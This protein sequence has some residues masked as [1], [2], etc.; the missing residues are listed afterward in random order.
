MPLGIIPEEIKLKKELAKWLSDQ[1]YC[2]DYDIRTNKFYGLN[3][4]QGKDI[5]ELSEKELGILEAEWVVLKCSEF[6]IEKM[7]E[8]NIGKL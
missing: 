1:D 5:T 4:T 6:F 3:E 8:N 2:V 7:N